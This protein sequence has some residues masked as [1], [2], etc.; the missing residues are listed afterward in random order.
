MK[1][2]FTGG[3]GAF[4]QDFLLEDYDLATSKF[5]W[6]S[7]QLLDISKCGTAAAAVG[8]SATKIKLVEKPQEASPVL[9]VPVA[10]AS[11]FFPLCYNN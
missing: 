6:C 7:Y 3:A 5:T 4:C 1:I 10:R 8:A 2:Y 11:L 9:I